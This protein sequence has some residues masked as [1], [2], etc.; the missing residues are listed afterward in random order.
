MNNEGNERQKGHYRTD[1]DNQTSFADLQALGE[2]IELSA[3]EVQMP[4]PS[5]DVRSVLF[6]GIFSARRPAVSFNDEQNKGLIG[7]IH[8]VGCPTIF[9]K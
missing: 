1:Q 6:E 2:R 7:K 8:L 3:G 5:E 4:V 9:E